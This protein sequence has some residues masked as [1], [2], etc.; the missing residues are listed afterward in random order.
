MK[1]KKVKLPLT[2]PQI[3]VFRAW[4]IRE[5]RWLFRRLTVW[6]PGYQGRGRGC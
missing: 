6:S 4:D 1:L 3:V 5:V 2:V